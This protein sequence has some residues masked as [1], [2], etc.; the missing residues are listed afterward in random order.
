LW[1]SVAKE[2]KSGEYYVPVGAVGSGRGTAL[3]R[4]DELARKVWDWTEEELKGHEI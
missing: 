3:A 1:A 2:V 4:D